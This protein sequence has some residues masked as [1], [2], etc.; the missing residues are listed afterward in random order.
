MGGGPR[1]KG[2]G[3][4][5]SKDF[6]GLHVEDSCKYKTECNWVWVWGDWDTTK[7]IRERGSRRGGGGLYSKFVNFAVICQGQ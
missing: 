2:E 6:Q 7:T 4:K 1:A 3:D 5:S